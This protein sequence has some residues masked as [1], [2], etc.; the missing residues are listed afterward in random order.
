[1]SETDDLFDA[2]DPD[3]NQYEDPAF[4]WGHDPASSY[5]WADDDEDWPPEEP[6][7]IDE[8][9]DVDGDDTPY[10]EADSLDWT[11]AFKIG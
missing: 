11:D 3:P 7:W 10:T 1:M 9:A 2:D 5:D 8:E 4:P 6:D